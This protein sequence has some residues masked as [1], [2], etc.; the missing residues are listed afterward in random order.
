[1]INCIHEMTAGRECAPQLLVSMVAHLLASTRGE[2]SATT[3]V[4]DQL[5]GI[6]VWD[7]QWHAQQAKRSRRIMLKA[8]N[9]NVFVKLV[10]TVASVA[11]PQQHHN[12]AML[13]SQKKKK[14]DGML[15]FHSV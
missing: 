5:H 14:N 13:R 11:A 4:A 7:W 2:R 3:N 8:W 9:G 10:P 6:T 1:M 12:D 15:L